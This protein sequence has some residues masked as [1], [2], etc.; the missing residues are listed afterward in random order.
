MV[1][2]SIAPYSNVRIK[3]NC[4]LDHL[5]PYGPSGPYPR[6]KQHGREGQVRLAVN[7]FAIARETEEAAIRVL[8]AQGRADLEAVDAFKDQV[9]NAGSST[10]NKTGMWANSKVNDLVQYNDSFK[11]KLIGSSKQIADRILLIESLRVQ[12]LLVAFL[13]Y[14]DD[15]KQF[16]EQV[17]SLVRKL[18][19]EGRGTDEAYEISLTGDV[20][21]EVTDKDGS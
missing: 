9:Q 15:I 2:A 5:R 16:G 4:R 17:L 20:Y 13:H 7:G 6:A 10:S 21:R 12:I 18:E 14:K 3:F 11:T 1:I 8:R 19:A